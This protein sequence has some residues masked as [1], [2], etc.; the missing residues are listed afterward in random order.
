[1]NTQRLLIAVLWMASL[2]AAY[3]IGSSG[4]AAD[5]PTAPANAITGSGPGAAGAA[6]AEE[7]AKAEAA[8]KVARQ[9]GGADETTPDGKPTV[10]SIIGRARLQIAGGMNGFMN[11]RGMMRAFAPIADLDDAQIPEALAEVERSVKEPQA[12]MMFY[13]MLL[14]QWAEKDGLSALKYAK[15]KVGTNK[16]FAMGVEGA[17]LGAWAHSNPEA[18]WKWYQEDQAVNPSGGDDR[19]RMGASALF[20]GM[21]SANLDT[22]LARVETLDEGSK[23]MAMM[24]IASSATTDSSRRRLLDRAATLPDATRH[25]VYQGVVGQWAMSDPEAAVKWV[26][27]L[28][29]DQAAGARESAGQMLLMSRPELAADLMLEGAKPEDKSRIYDQVAGRWAYSDAKAAGEWL[30]KQPQGPELDG[31]RRS[32]AATVAQKDPAGAM[33]WSTSVQDADQRAQSV[34]QTYFTW[35][36]R[37]AAAADAGLKNSGLPADKIQEI[38]RMPQPDRPQK[39]TATR[40]LGQ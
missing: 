38:L 23:S 11:I 10:A 1:M 15:E 33:A 6:S 30:T 21:A 25:Q 28:P 5:R 13:S 32:Y 40:V 29:A 18:A 4:T 16:M 22:A 2:T 26:R 14:S 24:G 17:V 20:A 31:A 34:T 37:D 7:A 35:R 12:Q 3:F 39:A 9:F 27:S 8:R 36:Q 19:M